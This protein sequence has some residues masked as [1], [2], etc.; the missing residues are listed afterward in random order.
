[1]S[2]RLTLETAGRV[3]SQI[4]HDPRTIAILL[5]L[6]C[7]LLWLISWMFSGTRVLDQFGPLL[8]GLFPLV[9][10]FLVTSVAT[11][12]ERTSGTL[13]RLMA[14]PI[15][16][17]DVIAGYAI[18]FALLAVVQAVVL[19]FVTV[20]LLGMNVRGSLW[21]VMLVAVL[22]AILGATLGLAASALARTEF[23]AVQMMPVILFPQLITCGLF[24]PR[25][26]MP[27]ILEAIS[28]VL[29]L[30]YGVDALQRLAVGA[31]FVDVR[32]DV[33]V[34]IGFIALAVVVGAT[35]LRRRTP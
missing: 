8:L 29:P 1:M 3:L 20:G 9:V 28:R 4:R 5:G 7:L 10:M 35:T 26:A 33:L 32:S 31:T 34:I 14:T 6:P 23:Q 27:G 12:R 30:T 25:A 15:G 18:A 21:V 16:K 11:L 24:M 19:T 22:D 13:E 17:G 2:A